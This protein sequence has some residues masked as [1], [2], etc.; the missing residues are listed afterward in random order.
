LLLFF[1]LMRMTNDM[2][3]SLFDFVFAGAIIFGTGL[4]YQLITKK[5]GSMAYRIAVGVALAATFILIWVNLAVGVIGS[6]DNPAN[7]MYGG[8]LAVGL[9]GAIIADLRPQG[10]ARALFA[11]ALAQAV[12]TV[13]ALALGLGYPE[14]RPAQIVFL[15]GFFVTLFVASALLF[16]NAARELTPAGAGPEG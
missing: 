16:R 15:N 2:N 6:E 13:I 12:I 1:V 8:V 4:T 3:W 11:M 9:I 7:L 5:A 14:N 10:M